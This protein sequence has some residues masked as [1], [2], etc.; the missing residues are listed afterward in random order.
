[1]SIVASPTP[2]NTRRLVLASTSAYRKML[3]ERLGVSFEVFRP[4]VDESRLAGEAPAD[5]AQR[6]AEAKARVAIANFPDALLIGCD[7]VAECAGRIFGKPGDHETAKQ[8]LL[9]LSGNEAVFHTA[10]CVADAT[11]GLTRSRLIP[12]HVRF[13]QLDAAR[14][15]RY[16][17]REMPYDCAGSAKSEGL[18][19]ALIESMSG[20]DPNAL[21]GLPL[22]ALIDLLSEFGFDVL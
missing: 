21:V 1:M 2:L 18:G 15:E 22:I 20:D 19:I 5:M 8:Q 13:R 9:D 7:Q 17:H 4:N 6:L 3:L 12:F 16:L 14:I 10:L 11:T